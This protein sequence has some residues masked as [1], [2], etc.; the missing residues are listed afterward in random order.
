MQMAKDGAPC[1]WK[2][3]RDGSLAVHTPKDGI[4]EFDIV[5][6][7]AFEDCFVHLEWLSPAGGNVK[8]GQRNGNSGIKLMERYEVQIMNSAQAPEP[9]QFN[10]AGSIYRQTAPDV[11]ASTGA[12]TWQSFDI[13][14]TAPKWEAITSSGSTSDDPAA[15][16]APKTAPRKI[17]NAR[18]TVVWN[19]ILVHND[20]EVKDKTGLSGTEA[21]GPARILLQ[22]HP[23]DAEG[24]VRFRNIWVT[25]TPTASANGTA[26]IRNPALPR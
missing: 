24:S 12:G 8:D 4:G 23:S 9:P 11:N 14:F 10:E 16:R 13:W 1:D 3:E 25:S 21:P 19:G 18:M 26:P 22:S 5:S 6:R 17:K 15:A 2:V 7:A 20:V